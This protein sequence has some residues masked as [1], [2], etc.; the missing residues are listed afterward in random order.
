MKKLS[1]FIIVVGLAV[2]SFSQI[3]AK[4]FKQ[5]FNKH[6]RIV[7]E[8]NLTD[9]QKE[10]FIKFHLANEEAALSTRAKLKKN[11]FE[12]KKLLLT[13]NIDQSKIMKLTES[14]GNLRNQLLKSKTKMW[15][16]VYNILDD[17]QKTVWKKHFVKMLQRDKGIMNRMGNRPMGMRDHNRFDEDGP[18]FKKGRR[19]F[20]R[21]NQQSEFEN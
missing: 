11:K 9:T 3:I 21:H 10:K 5:N 18:R 19:S 15:F 14:S 6:E 4:G 1:I 2:S 16:E 8:L 20:N 12:L 13:N 17:N 7:K